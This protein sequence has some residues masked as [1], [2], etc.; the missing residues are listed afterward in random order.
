MEEAETKNKYFKVTILL[1]FLG[2]LFVAAFLGYWFH[3]HATLS[4]FF[5]TRY[6]KLVVIAPFLPGILCSLRMWDK[7]K[8]N[9]R[10][11]YSGYAVLWGLLLVICLDCY[12]CLFAPVDFE[13]FISSRPWT[14]I[15]GLATAPTLLLMWYWRD[16]DRRKALEQKDN[17]LDQKNEE[18][19]H[20]ENE[21]KIKED[22][23]KTDRF[24]AGVTMLGDSSIA[25]RLGGIYALERL[26]KE[27][28]D[29]HWTVVETLAAFIRQ[30]APIVEGDQEK[31][32]DSDVAASQPEMTEKSKSKPAIDIQAALTVLGRRSHLKYEH[33]NILR[34]DLRIDL[35]K[36]DLRYADFPS[37]AHFEYTN[38]TDANLEGINLKGGYLTEA[39]IVGANLK[40]ANL[41][42]TDLRRA[43]LW[44]AN[45]EETQLKVANLQEANIRAGNLK[46]AELFSANLKRAQ[47]GGVNLKQAD[48][49]SANLEI[50]ELIEA[51]LEEAILDKANLDRANLE[52]AYLRKAH[53]RKAILTSADLAEANLMGA[54]LMGA[55]LTEAN[56]FKA[57][58]K[59]ALFGGAKLKGAI[60]LEANLSGV[61]FKTT[62]LGDMDLTWPYSMEADFTGANL[63][64]AYYDSDT[65][66]PEDFDPKPA[67]MINLDEKPESDDPIAR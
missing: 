48:L 52:E 8:K 42:A 41:N 12:Y 3:E 37:N 63:T 2:A 61:H 23:Q 28:K 39:Y 64:G 11:I 66:F 38:L 21:I 34:M 16:S 50:S 22:A 32:E 9:L 1:F 55:N 30:N 43:M 19:T 27:S 67:G 56:F 14:L 35:N 53:L 6:W 54:N 59:G 49:T 25:I 57:N 17:E 7:N 33:K 4:D 13:K 5:S 45:L 62:N 31:P 65:I 10:A 40:W 47:L 20:E 24:A 36:T 26:A 29:F 18:L 46:G 44:E 15:T 51:N 60:F 58:L